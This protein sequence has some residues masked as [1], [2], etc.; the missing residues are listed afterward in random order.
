MKNN[1]N[2]KIILLNTLLNNIRK[3]WDTF[4]F[5]KMKKSNFHQP[6]MFWLQ[7]ETS[8]SLHSKK[9]PKTNGLFKIIR[10][11]SYYS[12]NT[13]SLASQSFDY[14][15]VSFFCCILFVNFRLLYIIIK[16]NFKSRQ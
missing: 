1:N 4:L 5:R 10:A 9:G 13:V 2:L 8:I 3:F 12:Q 14:S 11:A 16:F 7:E 6:L 15:F